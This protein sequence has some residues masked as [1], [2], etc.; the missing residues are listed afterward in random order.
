MA[1]F[2]VVKDPLSTNNKWQ[3]GGGNFCTLVL[4]L[5]MQP[6]TING[7]LLIKLSNQ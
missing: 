1:L 2:D 7:R 3:R 5:K 4:E 6:K